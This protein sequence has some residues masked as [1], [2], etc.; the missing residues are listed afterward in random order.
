M[1]SERKRALR[2]RY[3]V[4]IELKGIDGS[5]AKFVILRKGSKYGAQQD[6]RVTLL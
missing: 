2:S 5:A 1:H 4:V 3:L 6:P